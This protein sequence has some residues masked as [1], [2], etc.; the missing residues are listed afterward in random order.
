MPIFRRRR[1]SSI[2]WRRSCGVGW[3]W[4]PVFTGMTVGRTG[5]LVVMAGVK[6]SLTEMAGDFQ[7]V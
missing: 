5:L 4:I 7:L 6:V 2:S 3:F 1:W